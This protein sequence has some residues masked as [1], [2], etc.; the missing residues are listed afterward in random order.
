[1]NE[2]WDARHTTQ[3]HSAVKGR[4]SLTRVITWVNLG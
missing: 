4:K 3:Q 1:M 2:L